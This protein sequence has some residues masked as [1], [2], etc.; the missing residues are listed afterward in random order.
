VDA[1][2]FERYCGRAPYGEIYRQHSG[3]DHCIATLRHERIR[4]RSLLV[5]GAAT[6]EV[7]RDFEDALGVRAFGCELSSWAHARIP[8]PFRRRIR[9]ADLRGYLPA[10]VRAG[11]HFDVL[12][13]S[14]LVYLRERDVAPVLA[15]AARVARFLHFYSSTSENFEPGDR[16]RALLRPRAWWRAHFLA[17]GWSPMRSRYLWRRA[18]DPGG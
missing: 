13:T 14:A 12:F 1:A 3:I 10:L 4:V 8:A 7:L 17:A 15:Q 18:S 11:R 5:L 9:R 16:Y 6:G 2:Y